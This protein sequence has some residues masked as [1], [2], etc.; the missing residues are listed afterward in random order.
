[1]V[2]LVDSPV[3]LSENVRGLVFFLKRVE[4]LNS[5][6]WINN[7][8]IGERERVVETGGFGE[9]ESWGLGFCGNGKRDSELR[10]RQK[11]FEG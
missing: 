2:L 10:W 8:L 5:Y 7:I 4:Q 1:M 3:L 11:S 9:R 6:Q